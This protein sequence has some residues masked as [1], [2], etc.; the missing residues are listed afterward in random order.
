V[1]YL[2]TKRSVPI[3]RIILFL[4]IVTV[5]TN[6]FSQ[7]TYYSNSSTSDFNQLSGWGIN[8][9]GSGANPSSLSS[10]ISLVINSDH[11]KNIS[12]FA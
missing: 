8:A 6:S 2:Q 3:K 7:T 10:S 11:T 4:L 9:D 1:L 12:A 5:A